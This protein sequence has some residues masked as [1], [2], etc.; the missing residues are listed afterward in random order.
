MDA[1]K[2]DLRRRFGFA[3]WNRYDVG[4]ER[5]FFRGYRVRDQDIPVW[6][7]VSR[8]RI[9]LPTGLWLDRASWMHAG[10]P[11]QRLLLLDTYETASRA[12]A[13]EVL[14]DLLAEFQVPPVLVRTADDIGGTAFVDPRG[15]IALSVLGNVVVR[16]GSGSVVAA[17]AVQVADHVRAQMA[18]RPRLRTADGPAAGAEGVRA[19]RLPSRGTA[20]R[21][22]PIELT[23]TG[24]AETV[25]G[26]EPGADTFLKV[27]S[28][29]GEVR[30][31]PEGRL[32][33]V[34]DAAGEATVELF[35]VHPDGAEAVRAVM[36]VDG[37]S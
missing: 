4:A 6:Q 18:G 25:A 14:V 7:V 33:L 34:P 9:R 16:I 15:G 22:A 23:A 35:E 20:G 17:P 1:R 5:L 8:R 10:D 21:P 12:A 37:P 26:A 24:R 28:R 19:V 11:L 31:D 13:Q 30:A 2:D 29:N 36:E 32:E 27:F 3:G